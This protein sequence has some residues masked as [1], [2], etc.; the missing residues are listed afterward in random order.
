MP[1]DNHNQL[2]QHKLIN[3]V[4]LTM[5]LTQNAIITRAN[6]CPNIGCCCQ[7]KIASVTAQNRNLEILK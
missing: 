5:N 4:I 7:N 2:F 1:L 3:R 6:Y